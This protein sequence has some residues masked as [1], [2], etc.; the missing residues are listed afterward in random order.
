MLFTGQLEVVVYLIYCNEEYVS[1]NL[2][3]CGANSI[4]V[5]PIGN[6]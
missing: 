2:G 4:E 3:S 1:V 6:N 5:I